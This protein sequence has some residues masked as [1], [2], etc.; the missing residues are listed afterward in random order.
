VFLKFEEEEAEGRKG[1]KETEG[2]GGYEEEKINVEWAR[3]DMA[4]KGAN[5]KKENIVKEYPLQTNFN[6]FYPHC[7]DGIYGVKEYEKITIKDVY[8]GIDWVF[9]NSNEKGAKYD[10]IVHPGADPAQ[11]QMVYSSKKKLNITNEGRIQI[12]I[13]QGKLTENAPESF[14]DGKLIDSKFKL[15]SAEKNSNGGYNTT[16]GFDFANGILPTTNFS[17]RIDPQ[18]TWATFYGGT[19]ADGPQSVATDNAGNVFV[20]GYTNSSNFPVQTAGTFFQGTNTGGWISF[21]LKFNNAGNLLWAT[22]YAGCQGSSIACDGSGNVF[23]TGSAAATN[24]PV[25]N[26]GTFFQGVL[27]GTTDAFILKFDNAGNRLWATYYGG[28]GSGYDEA[29][30]IACDVSGNVFVTGHTPSSGFPVQTAGTFFQGAN[31]GGNYD[32]FIL[33]FDNVGNRLW[34]TYYG[35]SGEDNG[36]TIACDGSGNVFITGLTTS[37]NFPVQN[38]GT[39]FQGASAGSTDAFILKFDNAGNRLWATYY[40]GSGA[41]NGYSIACDGSSN[42]FIT[43]ITASNNFPVQNAGTFFQGALA[44]G[45]DA[46]ILKFDNVGNRLWA[47]YYGGGSGN[48]SSNVT[49]ND[50]LAIDQCGTVYV[51]FETSSTDMFT[52]VPCDGG[53]YD[54]SHNGGTYDI[55]I[56]SFS[57][58][59]NLIWATYL[60]GNGLDFR[61]PM[62][63]DNAG[64]LFVSGEWTSGIID[65][66]YPLTNPGGGSYYDGTFNGNDDGFMVKFNKIPL[67]LTLTPNIVNTGCGCTGSTTIT[68]SGG[69]APYSYAWSNGQTT[70]TAT[71]LCSGSYTVIV[72]D[73]LCN[74]QTTTLSITGQAVILTPTQTNATCSGLGSAT[75]AVA[76]GSGLYTYTW[77]PSGGSSSSAAGLSPG[78]YTVTVTDA[79]VNGCTNTQTFTITQPSVNIASIVSTSVSCF[80]GSNGTAS[81]VVTGTSTPFS[82]SWTPSGGNA[83][84]TTG[85]SAGNYTV[86]VTD[87]N[88]C[89][90]T[91]TVSIT[92]PSIIIASVASTSV[93]CNGLSNGSATITASGGLAP[94]SYTWL[95]PG[96]SS[97]IASGLSVGNYTASVTDANGCTNTKTFTITQ[98][99]VITASVA[100][101]SINCIGLSNGSSTITAS[102]GLAPLS[103]TWLPTGGNTTIASGL[104]VGNYT[105]MV[106]DLNLCT[107]SVT[108]A[109]TQPSVIISSI[110]STSINCNGLSNGSATVTASGG[111]A[112]LSYTWLPTGGN[113]AIA[114]GLSVGNYTAM[115]SDLNLCTQSVTFAIAQASAIIAS[116][117]S[118]SINCYGL[119]NGSATLTASG[120]VAPLSYTWLPTGGNTTIASGL[121]IG[122]YTA[123]V[124]D[125]NLCTKSVTFAITQPTAAVSAVISATSTTGCGVSTG[126]A[127]VTVS[128]GI[129]AYT[130]SWIPSGGTTAGVSNLAA[131]NN[132]VTITDSNGC[133]KTAIAI[134]TAMGSSTVSVNSPT[135][136]SGT[137]I[138]LTASGATTYSWSPGLSS[139]SGTTVTANPSAT[140]VYTVTGT[141][142]A[143]CSATQTSTVNVNDPQASFIGMT[144][145]TENVETI[146]TLQNTSIGASNT[147]WETCFGSISTASVISLPLLD[148]GRCCVKLY[149]FEGLCVDSTT[150]CVTVS[151]KSR[152]NVPNVFTPNNDG[153]NDMFTLDAVGIGEITLSI[154]DRW[155]LKMFEST[156]SGNIRWDGKNKGGLTVA[157]GTYFYILKASGLDGEKYDLKGTIN[158]FQ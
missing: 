24:F 125:L 100:S 7:S 9:Y 45:S 36:N 137:S 77:S 16:I 75:V 135:I 117:A 131:G 152:L 155:G 21:I 49:N 112:P 121:S 154:F 69:C 109:I 134:I 18:L 38:A 1:T 48:E 14:L 26:A 87:F 27:A 139:T 118:T 17:L 88:G 140:T 71:G 80:G 99:S 103:Y 60:G 83:S 145:A 132:T 129:P 150:K 25:Q 106:S 70:Q 111:T 72:T 93:T 22:Y 120:G 147:E 23:V 40:G 31:A 126:G 67:T 76:G 47:T 84:T 20:T 56:A 127:T 105:A 128:G 102:G 59:G 50:K 97:T 116:A 113:T 98:P 43:G 37:T 66:T 124:S 153:K 58:T 13:E 138:V 10:F 157:E 136:C 35:G 133:T 119:S 30:S 6:F 123:M 110:A 122:N 41:D 82:Y 91:K 11:I 57:N 61:S 8:P 46:F 144:N 74:T 114:S 4:L 15:L 130:Y 33:K 55:F 90:G 85:L 107:Q 96:G 51:S 63:T 34:A 95:P 101:T 54:D 151:P 146:L 78:N 158:I 108:F 68:A 3:I 39:F 62:A 141:F 64:N 79:N 44:G 73:A 86:T 104:S 149:A 53:Y 42:M 19:A 29:T 142:T 81:A 28:S 92:Q 89:T 148:T 65:A 12:K 115:V 52:Q 5:I 156:A 94:L 143:G 32:V 2:M